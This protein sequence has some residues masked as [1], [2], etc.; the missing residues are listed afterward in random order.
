MTISSEQASQIG[1]VIA[2]IITAVVNRLAS[3]QDASRAAKD[4]NALT[5]TVV[6]A[7]ANKTQALSE[8][9]T[10]VNTG[11]G[12]TLRM[13]LALTQRI[14][15]FSN[16]PEDHKAADLAAQAYDRHMDQQTKLETAAIFLAGQQKG[17]IAA[18][19]SAVDLSTSHVPPAA[20]P[21]P[22]PTMS[23]SD[24]DFILKQNVLPPANDKTTP[25]AP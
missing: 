18:S 2:V 10:L 7:D 24:T 22:L 25:P 6:V 12:N 13:I 19:A 11:A 21:V 9:H 23:K 3:A 20:P 4:R 17:L 5:A 15:E 16:L 14:A 1:V 8:I